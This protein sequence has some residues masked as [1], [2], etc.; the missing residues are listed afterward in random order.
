MRWLDD[1]KR[2]AR[3]KWTQTASYREAWR[4]EKRPTSKWMFMAV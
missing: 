2:H 4:K 1:L 3:V